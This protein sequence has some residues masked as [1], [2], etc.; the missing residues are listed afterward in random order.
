M[1]KL[2][3]RFAQLVPS[4][5]RPLLKRQ[6]RRFDRLRGLSGARNRPGVVLMLHVGRCGS[7]VLAN[8]LA[9]NDQVHWDGK[10]PRK[11]LQ[12]YG[13]G[14]RDIDHTRWIAEQF[15]ISGDRFY[16]F[17]FKILADQYPSIFG[18]ST[19][20][21]LRACREIGVT[22]YI[23]LARRNTLRHVVSHYASKS[24]GNWHANTAEA[25]QKKVFSLDIDAISTGQAPGRPLLEYLA[26]V[27]AAHAEVRALLAGEN[28]LELEYERDI[29]AAGAE[30]AYARV[31]A[32]LGIPP[33]A[34]EIR[35]RK[36]NPFPLDNVL[37]NYDAVERAL[38]GTDFAWMSKD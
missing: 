12:L 6:I 7:T 21:F 11:A 13:E 3:S 4:K 16:G 30:T 23:L 22:H 35:N 25:V 32:F 37:E 36:M 10:L 15:A 14:V 38:A 1:P 18:T 31:C 17:E 24:R 9:Q 27:D 20:D 19:A 5:L 29:D 33:G 28:F 26:E 2:R 8:L 34:V